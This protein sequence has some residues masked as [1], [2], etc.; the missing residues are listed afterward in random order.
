MSSFATFDYVAGLVKRIEILEKQVA[1][2]QGPP[3]GKS[4]AEHSYEGKIPRGKYVGAT[5]DEV[6]HKDPW[7]VQWLADENKAYGLG[8]TDE[9]IQLAR[10]DPR[11]NPVRRR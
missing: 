6:V 9:H 10:D 5:H 2:L 7:Y 8:F 11:P 3:P 4:P 1:E